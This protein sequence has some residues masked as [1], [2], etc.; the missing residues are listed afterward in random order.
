MLREP[1]DYLLPETI[2]SL[3]G[4]F[5]DFHGWQYQQF[6]EGLV[7]HANELASTPDER[8][9][10][11]ATA[12]L[13]ALEATRPADVA[14]LFR[15]LQPLSGEA[16]QL[17]TELTTTIDGFIRRALVRQVNRNEAFLTELAA[18]LDTLDDTNSG[19]P[20][21]EGDLDDEEDDEEEEQDVTSRTNA[22][23][24]QAAYRRALL[25]HA[26]AEAVGRPLR[27]GTRSE[28]VIRWI[29]DRG[30]QSADRR[31]VGRMALIRRTARPFVN[32]VS[33]YLTGL[34]ARYR[35]Y[36]RALGGRNQWYGAR[37]SSADISPLELDMLILTILRYARELLDARL[38]QQD[39]SG[40]FWAPLQSV[41]DAYRAQILVDEATDFSPVQLACM[42]ALAHPS[43]RSFFACGDFNQRL[44]SWGARSTS[45]VKW[46]EPTLQIEKVTTGYRQSGELNALAR[47][48]ALTSGEDDPE[49]VLPDYAER[50][51]VRPV[52][53]EYVSTDLA[54]A[55][56]LATR[57]IEIEQAVGE[58]PTIAVLVPHEDRV[59]PVANALNAA[60]SDQNVNVLACPSGQ[61]MG[62]E[63]DIR[64]FDAQHI[65]GLEFEAVFFCDVDHLIGDFPDLFGKFLYVGATRAATYFG[66]TCKATLPSAL[67]EL[68][69]MFGTEWHHH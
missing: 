39:L 32:P 19:D 29:G 37:P 50:H 4:W 30:L 24:A 47:Q 8:L 26:R 10:T 28:R 61:V 40:T 5:G 1:V 45:Q 25:A 13:R 60:L 21:D 54:L 65:K 43:T 51:A 35:R 31:E 42:V 55:E 22:R 20:N 53:G 9:A 2:G 56:W 36:R 67:S 16:G 17:T 11:L 48:L 6:V 23:V 63:N 64:V 46:A 15:Q 44:T 41:L 3:A 34:P 49:I 59:V 12:L 58:L 14:R 7:R 66:L 52:L 38:V 57:V 33:L 69:K 62:Q 18:F 68:H 27:L